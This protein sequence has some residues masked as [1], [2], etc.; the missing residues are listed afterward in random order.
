[1]KHLIEHLT[2][3]VISFA[4]FSCSS[5]PQWADPEGHEKTEQLQRQYGPLI[6]GSWHFIFAAM[7]NRVSEIA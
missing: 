4:L 2:L 1:M 5:D 6:V 7:Q 3:L